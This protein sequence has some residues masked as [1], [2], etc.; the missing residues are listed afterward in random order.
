[1]MSEEKI[2]ARLQEEILR[3]EKAD[4]GSREISVLI[5]LEAAGNVGPGGMQ[6]LE[7]NVLAAQQGLRRKLDQLGAAKTVRAMTLANA[8]EAKL[9]PAGIREIAR[10]PEVKRIVWNRAEKVTA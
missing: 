2:E 9:M 8:V 4:E 6:A 7:E 10:L 3:A 1:M 5:E